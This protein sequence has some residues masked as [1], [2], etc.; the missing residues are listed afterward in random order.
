MAAVSAADRKRI[1][2]ALAGLGID[3]RQLAARKLRL[4]PEAARLAPVGLG[5]DGR[6]K[7]LAPAAAKAW[8]N[9]RASAQRRGVPLLLV[10]AFR[11]VEFQVALIRGKLT[12]G[13]RLDEVLRVNAPPG[14]SEHH[15]GRAVDIGFE[16]C[17]PLDESFEQTP[18]F[19]WLQRNARRFGFTMSYPRDNPQGYLYE[20]WHWR[21]GR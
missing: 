1:A 2:G 9:M 18:A 3:P 5:T 20:P 16:G 12:R 6:D 7:L 14:Y 15:T 19:A 11:S 13:A 8:L 21:H 10:S 4:F 17:P